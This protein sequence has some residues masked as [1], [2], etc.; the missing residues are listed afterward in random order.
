M[1]KKSF[2]KF[3]T[4]SSLGKY[5]PFS[6]ALLIFF[7]IYNFIDP[8]LI[9][10]KNIISVLMI[11]LSFNVILLIYHRIHLYLIPAIVLVAGIFALLIDKED[12]LLLSQLLNA[13]IDEACHIPLNVGQ[14]RALLDG[15]I[16]FMRLHAPVMN[17]FHS[18]EVLKTVLE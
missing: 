5:S 4:A 16:V 12:A 15:L 6:I 10:G 17:D 9:T 2:L 14:R 3:S 1:R 18:H 8:E 7:E 11:S 13:G